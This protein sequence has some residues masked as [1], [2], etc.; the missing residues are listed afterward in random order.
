MKSNENTPQNGASRTLNFQ[1]ENS[2]LKTY[3]A[4]CRARFEALL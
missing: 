1:T 3:D 4:V 2:N